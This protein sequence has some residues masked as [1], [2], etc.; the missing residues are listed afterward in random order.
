MGGRATY[1][2]VGGVAGGGEYCVVLGFDVGKLVFEN[3]GP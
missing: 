3:A 1:L 2:W